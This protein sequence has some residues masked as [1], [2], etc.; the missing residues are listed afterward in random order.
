MVYLWL[1][2]AARF[3]C[4]VHAMTLVLK[5]GI[6]KT[7]ILHDNWGYMNLNS[8]ET[9]DYNIN[10]I[11]IIYSVLRKK[12]FKKSNSFIAMGIALNIMLSCLPFL[13]SSFLTN[14]TENSTSTICVWF[15]TIILAKCRQSRSTWTGST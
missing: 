5:S 9:D 6:G 8:G 4:L 12:N 7:I 1:I 11:D 10:G 15:D 2:E 3:S 13:N 14:E